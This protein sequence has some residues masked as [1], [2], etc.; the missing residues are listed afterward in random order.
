[1]NAHFPPDSHSDKLVPA[2]SGAGR[3]IEIQNENATLL[4]SGAEP[5]ASSPRLLLLKLLDLLVKYRIF[6]LT[7]CGAALL[8]GFLAT[9]LSTPIYR[10][11]TTIQI[12]AQAPKV[13][14]GRH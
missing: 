8:M 11:T 10:A 3:S 14:A 2:L 7:C 6:I 12:D 1:M 9:F 4:S 13:L 5:A